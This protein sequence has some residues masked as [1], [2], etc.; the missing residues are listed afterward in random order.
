MRALVYRN[1]CDI[2]GC[3]GEARN[4]CA[5]CHKDICESHRVWVYNRKNVHDSQDR[6]GF[7]LCKA[8]KFEPGEYDRLRQYFL[9]H[10]RLSDGMGPLESGYSWWNDW[11]KEEKGEVP[12]M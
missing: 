6:R 3:E 8:C 7:N 1:V 4:S 5:N 2:Q 10:R 12:S 11:P 9:S